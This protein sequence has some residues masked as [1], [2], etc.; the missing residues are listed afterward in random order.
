MLLTFRDAYV[1]P[2]GHERGRPEGIHATAAMNDAPGPARQ[3]GR[4]S[5]ARMAR[6]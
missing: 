3:T 1:R 4:R 6:A 5:V 2:Q